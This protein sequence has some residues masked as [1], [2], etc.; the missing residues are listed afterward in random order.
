M[1]PVDIHTGLES[2]QARK[3][4]ARAGVKGDGEELTDIMLKLYK[5]FI[6]NDALLA[7]INPLALSAG[8]SHRGGL[9]AGT[10]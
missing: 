10:G 3:I 5:C 1:E 9:Q 2:R 4:L 6:S 7:E 8:V